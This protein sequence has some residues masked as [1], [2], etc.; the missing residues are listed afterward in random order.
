MSE[1]V[2]SALEQLQATANELKIQTKINASQESRLRFAGILS[3]M[4]LC[5]SLAALV[6]AFRM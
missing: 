1:V 4:A 2:A 3:L 6:I 5:L